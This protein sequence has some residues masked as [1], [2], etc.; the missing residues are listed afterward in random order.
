[1]CVRAGRQ[2]YPDANGFFS[3]VEAPAFL[4]HQRSWQCVVRISVGTPTH[5]PAI[6]MF[7]NVH[8]AFW[9]GAPGQRTEIIKLGHRVKGPKIIKLHSPN[10]GP[11]WVSDR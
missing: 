2:N 6:V 3:R 1:M 4:L 7:L 8:L 10:K 11:S 9:L 5:V